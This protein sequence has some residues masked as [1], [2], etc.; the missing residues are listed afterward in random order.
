M[1]GFYFVCY[2]DDTIVVVPYSDSRGNLNKPFYKAEPEIDVIFNGKKWDNW[3]TR[4]YF[5]TPIEAVKRAIEQMWPYGH[6]P[7]LGARY[8]GEDG[9][10]VALGEGKFSCVESA[11]YA[12]MKRTSPGLHNSH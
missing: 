3:N 7:M 10:L 12:H 4:E 1:A 6:S 9:V 2:S 8:E 5:D 11:L